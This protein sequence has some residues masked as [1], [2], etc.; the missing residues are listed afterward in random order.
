MQCFL[1]KTYSKKFYF[2]YYVLATLVRNT[3]ALTAFLENL[4]LSAVM[5]TTLWIKGRA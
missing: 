1:S 3:K 4:S 5:E 2:P